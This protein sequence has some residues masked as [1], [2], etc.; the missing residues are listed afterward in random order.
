M[1]ETGGPAHFLQVRPKPV[2][3]RTFERV[4]KIGRQRLCN[5]RFDLGHDFV[6]PS[7]G[8]ARQ[9]L[10]ERGRMAEFGDDFRQPL[11]T[12]GLVQ[13]RINRAQ[14]RIE[15]L[16]LGF[17]ARRFVAMDHFQRIVV[18]PAS[19]T[20]FQL[21]A[22][23]AAMLKCNDTGSLDELIPL[24]HRATEP[25]PLPELGELDVVRHYTNLSTMNINCTSKTIYLEFHHNLSSTFK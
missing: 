5:V 9:C 19:V 25:P 6:P 20:V 21:S 22:H 11:Q 2:Q 15:K 24:L 7:A 23:G 3:R 8:I 13:L 1:D 16:Q 14:L 4:G 17:F 12:R 10:V 18:S